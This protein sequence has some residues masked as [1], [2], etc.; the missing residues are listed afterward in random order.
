MV[1]PL[2]FPLLVSDCVLTSKYN[3]SIRAECGGLLWR[4]QQ[5]RLLWCGLKPI[6]SISQPITRLGAQD[7]S[8]AL[9][10]S[11]HELLSTHTHKNKQTNKQTNKQK[12][13]NKK[14][15][16]KKKKKKKKPTS[17]VDILRLTEQLVRSGTTQA[18][19]V[20][21]VHLQTFP[22]QWTLMD[23]VFVFV[24]L[25]V[26]VRWCCLWAEFFS[27]NGVSCAEVWGPITGSPC[28]SWVWEPEVG[29][30]LWGWSQPWLQGEFQARP[31]LHTTNH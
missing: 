13:K 30:R 18:K 27:L 25:F 29:R 31:G 4:F 28:N 1:F 22:K 14:Q 5:R 20:S 23:Q 12:T 26:S 10:L 3:S 24:C 17:W 8:V 7:P 15:K 6:K 2:L 19:K 16:T 11:Q 9:S 21:L